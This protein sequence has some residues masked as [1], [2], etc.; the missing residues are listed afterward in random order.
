VV[1]T[2]AFPAQQAVGH[3]AAPADVLGCDLAEAMPQLGLLNVD[4]LATMALGAAVLSPES[5]AGNGWAGL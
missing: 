1:H 3:P 5:Y 2:P 4:D